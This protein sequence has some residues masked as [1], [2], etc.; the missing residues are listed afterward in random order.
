MRSATTPRTGVKFPVRWWLI[1]PSFIL[2]TTVQ[3]MDKANV[4]VILSD[5]AFRTD[6]GIANNPAAVGLLISVFTLPYGLS[7]FVWGIVS[8]KIGARATML[9]SVLAWAVF[10]AAGGLATNYNELLLTRVLLGFAEGSLWSVLQLTFFNWFPSREK[11]RAASAQSLGGALLGIPLG[12]FLASL[13]VTAGGWRWGFFGVSILTL[14][15]PLPMI[16]FLYR[17]RPDQHPLIGQAELDYLHREEEILRAEQAAKGPPRAVSLRKM[18]LNKPI[19]WVAVFSWVMSTFYAW[20][21][22]QAWLPTF[23]KVKLSVSTIEMGGIVAVVSLVG[24]AAGMVGATV[25]DR[26]RR[27]SL[28]GAIG[29]LGAAVCLTIAGYTLSPTIALAGLVLTFIFNGLANSVNT[30][31]LQKIVPVEARTVMGKA[32]GIHSGF[33][34]SFSAIAPVA[35]GGLVASGGFGAALLVVTIPLAIGG[36][37]AV[38]VFGRR[39][40]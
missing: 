1:L 19:Y 14:L 39:G 29:W 36:L 13:L 15:L 40:Y 4:P 9:V 20:G 8:D 18:V 5:L 34:A 7:M 37:L 27:A 35:M 38:F 22:S 33:A 26:T 30:V 21:F 3:S 10:S 2:W 12:T 24:V 31:Y 28:M 32:G 17:D 6:M 25:I 16:F 23:V 11:G